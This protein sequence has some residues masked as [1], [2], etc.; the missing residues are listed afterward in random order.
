M[1]STA[2]TSLSPPLNLPA[3]TLGRSDLQ[4]SP[5]CLGTMTFGEQVSEAEAFRI[6]DRAVERG[7]SFFDTAEM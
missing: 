5:I 4:V 3:V 1:T 7:V 6:M 2:T